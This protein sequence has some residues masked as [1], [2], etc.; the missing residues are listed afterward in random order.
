MA[1]IAKKDKKTVTE[2]WERI[3]HDEAAELKDRIKV[4]E[5][6]SKSDKSDESVSIRIKV[7]YEK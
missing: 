4:S 3:M 2:F 6:L 1:D 5:L 7:E